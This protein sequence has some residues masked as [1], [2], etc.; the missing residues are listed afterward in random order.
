MNAL[1]LGQEDDDD[2]ST[3]SKK[4]GK[5]G[6]RAVKPKSKVEEVCCRTIFFAISYVQ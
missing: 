1:T 3:G 2:W 6:K 4:K 5:G